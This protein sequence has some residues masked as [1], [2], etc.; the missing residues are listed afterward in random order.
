M[1]QTLALTTQGAPQPKLDL[2]PQRPTLGF[3]KAVNNFKSVET[4]KFM[5]SAREVGVV[6]IATSYSIL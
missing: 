5:A 6:A 2:R 4:P 3:Q 1:P